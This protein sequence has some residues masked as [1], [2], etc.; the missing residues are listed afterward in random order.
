M[1]LGEHLLQAWMVGLDKWLAK[2]W[3]ASPTCSLGLPSIVTHFLSSL[4]AP[5]KAGS[6]LVDFLSLLFQFTFLQKSPEAILACLE[7]WAAV[8]D[9]LEGSK[10]AGKV[11]VIGR[12]TEALAA[13]VSELL[14][15]LHA[16]LANLDHERIGEDGTT[17]WQA[18]LNACL[19]L[20]MRIAELLPEQTMATVEVV[21]RDTSAAYLGLENQ[22][23]GQQQ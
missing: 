11:E 4:F 18:F 21:L 5:Q 17:E 10:E 7:V 16:V 23:G 9:Y 19:E 20:V 1:E 8:C 2:H 12:Y 13:L 14:R 3:P 6:P 15:R 22:M